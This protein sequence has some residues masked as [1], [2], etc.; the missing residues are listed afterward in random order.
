LFQPKF[1]R[2]T[3]DKIYINS[4]RYDLELTRTCV[5]SVR[6]W[7]PDIPVYLIVDYS[8]GRI[9][10]TRMM[11]TW[12]LK[13]LDTGKQHYGWG[14]GKFEPLFLKNNDRFLVLD[15]DTV[16]TGPVL[17]KLKELEADFIV[18]EEVQPLEKFKTLYYDPVKA[19]EMFPGFNYPGY[20]FNTGQWIGKSDVLKKE[21]FNDFV[22]WTPSPKL[23]H[24]E[25]F[26]Q[27][28][29]GIFNLLIHIKEMQQKI[30]V[31]KMP[32]MIWPENGNA[33]FIQLASIVQKKADAPFVIH[34]AG[35]KF[36]ALTE[37]PR[38]D[39]LQF[40]QQF[41]YSKFPAQQRTSDKLL[42]RYLMIEKKLRF[43]V[44]RLF[45]NK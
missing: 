13:I 11:K 6:Y 8:N 10:A 28:D 18:D 27:A 29:Q 33:D 5:A 4:H 21:D 31:K 20:S 30:A 23:K 36:K 2:L 42:N 14:F 22:T 32:L 45:S 24:P 26:K 35:I 9:P 37:Y 17:D 34:W 7:Y 19:R 38:A 12:D 15:A 25:Y 3:I 44:K 16:M 39:I 1:L 40:Y 41:Y 43:K